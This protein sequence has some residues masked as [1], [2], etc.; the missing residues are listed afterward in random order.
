LHKEAKGSMSQE[1]NRPSPAEQ[2]RINEELLE[3]VAHARAAFEKAKA[4]SAELTTIRADLGANHSDGTR[5]SLNALHI[6][7][8]ATL[9]YANAIKALSEFT[10]NQKLPVAT[11]ELH[12]PTVGHFKC[13]CGEHLAF[14]A[15]AAAV[16]TLV[17]Q[18]R[19]GNRKSGECP[20]CGCIHETSPAPR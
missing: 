16:A 5:A 6:Q 17:N 8:I 7:Q 3:R 13:R 18:K 12:S 2:R 15:E 9:A 19:D 4:A 10:L 1:V 14:G 11:L 20:R